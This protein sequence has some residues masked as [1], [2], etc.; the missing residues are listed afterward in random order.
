MGPTGRNSQ[1][2]QGLGMSVRER[3][4][5][6]GGAKMLKVQGVKAAA[7]NGGGRASGER[8]KRVYI[9]ICVCVC[10]KERVNRLFVIKRLVYFLGTWTLQETHL[11]CLSAVCHTNLE[12]HTFDFTHN[13]RA[14]FT[15]LRS[16][17]QYLLFKRTRTSQR[18]SWW[19][20]CK[21][22][23]MFSLSST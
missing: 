8:K 1:G 10:V 6:R 9:Y 13:S 17:A 7:K 12:T 19:G 3:E 11:A 20:A 15:V 21:L 2:N 23:S 14:D 5:G 4:K 16:H 18:D 22:T